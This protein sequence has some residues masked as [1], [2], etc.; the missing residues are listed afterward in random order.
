MVE[1]SEPPLRFGLIG[2]G[3]MGA[4]FADRLCGLGLGVV[5]HDVDGRAVHNL[6][7]RHAGLAM[8]GSALHDVADR[9]DVLLLSLPT[10]GDVERALR[11][12]DGL[13]R[14]VDPPTVVIDL[15]SGDPAISGRLHGELAARGIGFLDVGVSGGPGPARHGTL[16]LMVGGDADV[17]KRWDGVLGRFGSAIFHVGPPGAGHATKA[18]NNLLSAAHRVLFCE[19]I[20]L[21]AKM[22]LPL[23][24]VA[25][26]IASGSGRDYASETFTARVLGGRQRLGF[27]LALMRKDVETALRMGA[28]HDVP[29]PAAN[30][31]GELYRM[32]LHT[33]GADADFGEVLTYFEQL[34]GVQIAPP[35]D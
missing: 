18:L 4:A 19:A 23:D 28:R 11:G 6:L 1:P 33:R 9:C 3:V 27:R 30:V 13:A 10:S 7:E 2:L 24:R 15:T 35:A 25:E 5:A 12:P 20:V 31:V 32:I 21:A 16:S 17:V 34:S 8:A 29:M 14:V 22:D 26:A